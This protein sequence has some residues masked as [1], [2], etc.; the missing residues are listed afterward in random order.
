MALIHSPT[1]GGEV[2]QASRADSTLDTR[3]RGAFGMSRKETNRPNAMVPANTLHAA[4]ARITAIGFALTALTIGV[5]RGFLTRAE[6]I[7]RTL[8]TL[9]FL[10]ESEQSEA[11]DATGFRGFYYHFMHMDSGRRAWECELSTTDSRC[12]H[13]GALTAGA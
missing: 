4:H 12:L 10:R 3:Q 6:A 7:E 5:E 8:T 11:P 2:V 1:P 9:R 13:V